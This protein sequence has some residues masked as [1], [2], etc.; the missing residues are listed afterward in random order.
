MRAGAPGNVQDFHIRYL[1][2]YARREGRWQLLAWQ[3]TRLPT[4]AR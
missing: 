4:D 3:A 2:V 1:A